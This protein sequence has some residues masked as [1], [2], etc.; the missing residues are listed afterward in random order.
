MSVIDPYVYAAHRV[1]LVTAKQTT[2]NLTYA[3][4]YSINHAELWE[5]QVAAEQAARA[6]W[7]AISLHSPHCSSCDDEPPEKAR[8]T[9]ENSG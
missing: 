6:L 3:S 1:A 8:F 4:A 2:E 9:K 7:N 5:L